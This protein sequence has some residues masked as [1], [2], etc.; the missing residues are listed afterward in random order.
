MDFNTEVKLDAKDVT[1]EKPS[2]S[3]SVNELKKEF[4]KLMPSSATS[5]S[6]FQNL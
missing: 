3:I 4:E 6:E 2:D 5:T 1:V